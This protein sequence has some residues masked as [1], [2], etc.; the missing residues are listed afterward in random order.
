M[1]TSDLCLA[2]G[3]VRKYQTL[4]LGNCVFEVQNVIEHMCIG[5]YMWLCTLVHRCLE[6]SCTYIGVN[7][8][9]LLPHG[10]FRT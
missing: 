1:E 8:P 6:Y 9:S 5:T 4:T 10:A 3:E 2:W 7:I